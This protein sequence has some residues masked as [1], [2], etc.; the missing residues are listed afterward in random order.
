MLCYGYEKKVL[1]VTFDNS[2]NIN[3]K[4][5]TTY[6]VGNPVFGVKLVNGTQSS[7]LDNWISKENKDKQKQLC[8][9][10]VSLRKTAHYHKNE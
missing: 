9:Y 4:E 10:Q 3:K 7:P 8:T 1:V 2:T 6:D 5:T